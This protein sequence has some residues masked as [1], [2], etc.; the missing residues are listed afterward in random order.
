MKSK[1]LNQ[2]Q[3]PLQRL[4]MIIHGKT[5]MIIHGSQ[6]K[7]RIMYPSQSISFFSLFLKTYELTS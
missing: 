3:I 5:L 4:L 7:S 1:K 6:L 2:I